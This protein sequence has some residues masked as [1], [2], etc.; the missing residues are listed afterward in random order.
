MTA[1]PLPLCIVMENAINGLLA[2]DENSRQNAAPLSGK[3]LKIELSDLNLSFFLSISGRQDIL[4]MSYG[5]NPDV[6]IRASSINLAK[7][8]TLEDAN[9]MVL[10]QD[11]NISG[12][13]ATVSKVQEF[14]ASVHI[15][16][17]EHLSRLTGDLIA[18]KISSGLRAGASWLRNSVKSL[19]SDISEYA[20]Y[21]A[22]WMPDSHESDGFIKQVNQLRND[23]DRLEA[24]MKRLVHKLNSQKH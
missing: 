4:I 23:V 1:L 11:V 10:N 5:E 13:V 3:T 2:L 7:M 6:V 22:E 15:D 16:W 17:E 19:S 24:K 18:H 14:F 12:D 20:R 9:R 21:E 8:S